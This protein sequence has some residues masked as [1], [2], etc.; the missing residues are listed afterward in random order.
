[1]TIEEWTDIIARMT[2]QQ[3]EAMAYAMDVAMLPGPVN[4]RILHGALG[5]RPDKGHPLND[6][7]P[8]AV[9]S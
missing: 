1:M 9:G 2:P 4:R 6:L 7:Y 5:S 3:R 8:A